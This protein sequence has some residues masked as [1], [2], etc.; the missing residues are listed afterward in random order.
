L[1]K[2]RQIQREQKLSRQATQ[3]GLEIVMLELWV[4]GLMPHQ[5]LLSLTIRVH[6]RPHIGSGILGVII[7]T[8]SI[9]ENQNTFPCNFSRSHNGAVRNRLTVSTPFLLLAVHMEEEK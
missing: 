4:T 6:L 3:L 8:I 7:E 2:I 5:D 9:N 1:P